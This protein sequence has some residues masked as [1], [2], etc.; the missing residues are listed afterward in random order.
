MLAESR[1]KP[2]I[3]HETLTWAYMI[4]INERI[5]RADVDEWTAFKSDNE[6]LF[7]R[8]NVILRKYYRQETLDSDL[9]RRVFLLPDAA[10]PS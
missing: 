10:V 6:D 7:Q 4:L 2:E 5:Q 9:A 3:Y 1:G 8:G